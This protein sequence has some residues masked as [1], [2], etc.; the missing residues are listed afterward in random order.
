MHITTNKNGAWSFN[1]NCH[2]N[3]ANFSRKQSCK[4]CHA[5]GVVTSSNDIVKRCKITLPCKTSTF[6]WVIMTIFTFITTYVFLASSFLFRF[7]TSSLVYQFPTRHI[8]TVPFYEIILETK[9]S[10]F[11]KLPPSIASPWASWVGS[12]GHF[13]VEFSLCQDD[14][15]CSILACLSTKT[16][17]E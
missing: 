7:C 12:D 10:C 15:N 5:F 11:S 3:F 9:I 17:N 2:L 16:N 1:V 13:M 4:Y 6:I 8:V 14:A